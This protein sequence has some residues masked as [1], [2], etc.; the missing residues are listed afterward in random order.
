VSLLGTVLLPGSCPADQL[1]R[2]R[3]EDATLGQVIR[4][5]PWLRL[6]AADIV[7]TLLVVAGL[8]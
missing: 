4:T 1:V 6:I 2:A 7:V 5:L 8:I 3:G